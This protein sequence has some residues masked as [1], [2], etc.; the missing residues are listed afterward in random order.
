M[1]AR[2][3]STRARDVAVQQV[4]HS[5]VQRTRIESEAGPLEET[6]YQFCAFVCV[7]VPLLRR[8]DPRWESREKEIRHAKPEETK[9]RLL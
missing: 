6:E 8:V 7:C 2:R 1:D 9:S 5:R 3:T 4:C